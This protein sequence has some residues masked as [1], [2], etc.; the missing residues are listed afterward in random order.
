[1]KMLKQKSHFTLAVV[2]VAAVMVVAG[3][4]V[5]ASNTGFKLNKPLNQKGAGQIGNNWTSLPYFNPYGNLGAFCTQTGLLTS[6]IQRD[7]IADIDP[8]TGATSTVTCGTAAAT[9]RAIFTGR[10]IRI[11]RP[12]T[13]VG[14]TSIIIVGS[15][16]PSQ[17]ITV[18]D[19]GGGAVGTLW[20]AVPYHTTAVTAADLCLSSGLT[21]SGIQRAT[22][23]RLNAAT[24]GFTTVTCGTAAAS[25]LNLVLGEA[26]ALREPNGPLSFIPAHF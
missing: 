24:G 2:L 9:A 25:T 21:S 1:M 20:F 4:V 26:V 5:T 12:T 23:Q 7:T 3:G 10:G 19:A 17:S 18:P 22:V 14:T 15:H 16:N 11:S 8:V 6:G 13:I